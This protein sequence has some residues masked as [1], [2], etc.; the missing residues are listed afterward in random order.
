MMQ[1]LRQLHHSAIKDFPKEEKKEAKQ[2]T[3]YTEFFS[4][5]IDDQG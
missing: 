4:W 3:G 5:G 2:A 1:P